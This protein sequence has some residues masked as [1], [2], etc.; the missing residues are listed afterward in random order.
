[1]FFQHRIPIPKGRMSVRKR[2]RVGEVTVYL[3]M[4]R[5]RPSMVVAQIAA[6]KELKIQVDEDPEPDP[7]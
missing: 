3:T 1:M 5:D 6:P 7:D 4:S 2:I